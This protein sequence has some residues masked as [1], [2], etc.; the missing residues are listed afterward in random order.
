VKR[1]RSGNG[2]VTQ[3]QFNPSTARLELL[4]A[5]PLAGAEPNAIVLNEAY[6]YDALVNLT[7][8]TQLKADLG[9][10]SETLTYD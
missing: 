9:L 4:A 6:G 10:L 8:R 1:H 3:R 5:G 2:I 7:S